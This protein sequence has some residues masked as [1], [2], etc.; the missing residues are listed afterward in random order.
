MAEAFHRMCNI[1]DQSLCFG[2]KT[3]QT[4]LL[5]PLFKVAHVLMRFIQVNANDP[6]YSAAALHFD[7][8]FMRYGT[9][10]CI[11]NLIKVHR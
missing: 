7:R 9:P 4:C 3:F 8:M 11:L 2:L 1:V 6:F 10:V 5:N